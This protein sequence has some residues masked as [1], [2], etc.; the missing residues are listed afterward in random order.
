M[1][2]TK[3]DMKQTLRY[4]KIFT[5]VV[6]SAAMLGFTGCK[7]EDSHYVTY[8]K[9]GPDYVIF[10]DT[11]CTE[12]LLLV[13]TRGYIGSN[14]AGSVTYEMYTNVESWKL[15]PDYSKCVNQDKEWISLWPSEG[16][17]DGRFVVTIDPNVDQGE[18][19]YADINI[20]SGDKIVKTIKVEQ[21]ASAQI[22]LDIQSFLR[23]VTFYA[24]DTK[25]QT[26]PVNANVFWDI[27]I[28]DDAEEWITI[29]DVKQS[30][31][32]ISVKPN[33]TGADRTA[34]LQVFQTSNPNNVQR[35]TV[36]QHAYDEG[37]TE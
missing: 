25:V 14:Y 9:G 21:N 34:I 19:R 30:K 15:V 33:T 36:T 29:S 16:N 13:D 27:M 18:T 28:S 26:I 31:F 32:D 23:N 37:A 17:H 35:V 20:V 12:E 22:L 3:T 24:N 4:A 6:A 8:G 11:G 7:D 10:G 2:N 1:L 5:A